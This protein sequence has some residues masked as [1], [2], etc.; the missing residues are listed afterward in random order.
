[1]NKMEDVRIEKVTLNFGAGKENVKLEKGMKIVEVIGGKKPVQTYA[2]KRIPSWGLR[3]GLVI[4]C[5]AT[6]R[7]QGA[8]QLLKR[9]LS[10]KSFILG[11]NNFDEQGNISFGI[12]EY[13]DV[14]GAQ[15]DPTVGV[16]GFQVSVTL[17][18]SGYRVKKRYY[19]PRR[20]GKKHV[21]TKEQGMAYMQKTFNVK[22]GEEE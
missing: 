1:M 10:A 15:Y 4:G 17:E 7:K 9:L 3:P 12:P 20:V 8:E 5:K 18:K 11:E 19:K 16:I 22:I 21:V 6:F 14:E 13:I 2:K